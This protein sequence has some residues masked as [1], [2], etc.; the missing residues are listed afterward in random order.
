MDM[1]GVGPLWFGLGTRGLQYL[2]VGVQTGML[3]VLKGSTHH[4]Q[5]LCGALLCIIDNASEHGLPLL[6]IKRR[7]ASS[8]RILNIL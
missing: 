3:F 7:L 8:V 6:P 1:E 4:T 5:R 2:D